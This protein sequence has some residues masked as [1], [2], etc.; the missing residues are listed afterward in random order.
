[1]VLSILKLAKVCFFLAGSVSDFELLASIVESNDHGDS[2]ESSSDIYVEAFLVINGK[3]QCVSVID[4]AMN[5]DKCAFNLAIGCG[6]NWALSSVDHGKTAK[7]GRYS[8]QPHAIFIQ[9]V[10]SMFTILKKVSL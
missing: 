7:Q 10:K 5:Y 9:A 8:M 1:M 6:S 4:G 2:I 3:V